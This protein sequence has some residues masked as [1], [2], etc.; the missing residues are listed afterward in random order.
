MDAQQLFGLMALA[1]EQQ[2]AVKDALAGLEKCG[3]QARLCVRVDSR[4]AYGKEGERR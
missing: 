4:Q 2:K 1:Q 3:E